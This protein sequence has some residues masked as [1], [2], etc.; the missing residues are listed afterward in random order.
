MGGK[1]E[2]TSKRW[3]KFTTFYYRIQDNP[4]WSLADT[5]NF[6]FIYGNPK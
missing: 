4:D 3:S 1:V 6:F 5:N 2:S